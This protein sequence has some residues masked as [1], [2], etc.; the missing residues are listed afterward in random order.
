MGIAPEALPLL[1][2]RFFRVDRPETRGV[3]GVGVGLFVVRE[4]VRLHGG[5]V[6]VSSALDQG[7]AFT[8][9]LPL[10][11]GPG[12]VLTPEQPVLGP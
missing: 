7:S 5:T 1:F 3:S 4:I 6:E 12:Q 10:L 2:D 11:G 8:V 9:R